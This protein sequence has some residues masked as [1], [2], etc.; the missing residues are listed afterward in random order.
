MEIHTVNRGLTMLTRILM[1][2]FG[3]GWVLGAFKILHDTL[4]GGPAASVFSNLTRTQSV[5]I[6]VVG[7]V[8]WFLIGVAF[9]WAGT[10]K[11]DNKPD[12]KSYT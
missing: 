3:V 11:P 4:L 8:L 10:I 12:K 2:A 7:A 1:V 6:D 5:M 9:I